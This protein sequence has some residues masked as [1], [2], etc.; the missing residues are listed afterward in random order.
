MVGSGR[1]AV[2][3]TW[4][5]VSVAAVAVWVLFPL[6]VAGATTLA[7][8]DVQ[9]AAGADAYWLL[10]GVAAPVSLLAFPYGLA[11]GLV[12]LPALRRFG[13]GYVSSGTAA[14]AEWRPRARDHVGA[15][16]LYAMLTTLA[17]GAGLATALRLFA[18]GGIDPGSGAGYTVALM[19][20]G[21][22]FVAGAFFAVQCYGHTAD[23]TGLDG[24]HLAGYAAYALALLSSPFVSLAVLDRL[25]PR[26]DVWSFVL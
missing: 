17:A 8:L 20:F 3:S 22:L 14:L 5:V 21:G 15:A 10:L 18:G 4:V 25:L 13:L 23:E 26:L 12:T 6:A 19:V 24:R 7:G 2:P 16:T 1:R 9:P 11:V